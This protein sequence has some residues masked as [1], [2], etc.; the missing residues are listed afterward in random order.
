MRGADITQESLFTTVHLET[1]VPSKHPLRAIRAM[2]DEALG[3]M[4]WLF[5]TMYADTG[6]GSIPPERLIRA[7]LL[8]VL[9]S[10]RSERR[11]VEQ[12]QYNLLFRWF[13]GL[14]IDDE[15]WD[16]STF[17]HNRDRLLDH[18]VVET[19]LVELLDQARRE[20][21]LSG[22]HFSVDGTLIRA[23][24]SHK[25]FRPRD[26]G[27]DDEPPG[28][29]G[30]NAEADF[31]GHKRCNDTHASTSD[32]ESRL[33]RKSPGTAS[34]LCY[35]G[36]LVTDNRHGLVVGAAV[37]EANGRAEREVALQLLGQLPG[38]HRKTVGADRAYDTAD[39]VAG[40]REIGI[41]PHVARND[42]G[43]RRSRIDGRTTRH[44]G[45]AISQ[46]KRKQIEEHFGWG[47]TVGGIRQTLY[48]GL[49][50]VGQHFC[51]TM[52]ASNLVRMRTLAV[53]A[54]AFG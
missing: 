46:G 7:S 9:Y 51:L 2:V 19:L 53:S 4:S 1:F 10:I 45:Y 5:N 39:F 11:L 37:S 28:D 22:E 27:D 20:D 50:R 40:V 42:S 31:R 25:S 3:R 48:R 33:Y 34:M 29:G 6:R 23:W 12:I 35:Q 52:I 14:S 8:Q 18:G 38:A 13:V 26:E 49:K 21:W 43:N 41:T 44:P 17:S 15:V 32:P 24:A 47:K 30:R 36:H 16:H 54:G